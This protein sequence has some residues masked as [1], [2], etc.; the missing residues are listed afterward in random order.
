MPDIHSMRKIIPPVIVFLFVLTFSCK[1]KED[2]MNTNTSVFR[3]FS[4]M[5]DVFAYMD[6]QS[7]TETFDAAT[8]KS[9]YG[10]SGTRYF[11]PPY[12]FIDA[13]G[14]TISGNVQV[15]VT[16]WLK[17]GDM[18]F[19][20]VLPVSDGMPLT[21]SGEIYV[22]AT[23]GGNEVF[24]KPGMAYTAYVPGFGSKD[25]V[26]ALFRGNTEGGTTA[27]KVNWS[28]SDTFK[29][30]SYSYA[31]Y[32]Q[33]T[34]MMICDSF[35]FWNGDRFT[36]ILNKPEFKITVTAS[37]ADAATASVMN[38]YALL[39]KENA[40]MMLGNASGNVFNIDNLPDTSMHFISFGL[41]KGHFYGGVTAGKPKGGEN[42]KLNMVEVDPKDFKAQ[43]NGLY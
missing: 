13:T 3:T 12:C 10:N 31:K 19:G 32:F 4:S 29:T 37:G 28:I 21:S 18:I 2:P 6:Q 36:G 33:D 40:L 16:E 39:D 41:I 22:T 24:I 15:V 30:H 20:G 23:K 1:K 34:V 7:K 27:N 8:G 5:D 26:M 35:R 17:K 11:F 42:F 14:A 9:F 43:I 38:G 25:T